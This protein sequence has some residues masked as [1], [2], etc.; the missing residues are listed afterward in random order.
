MSDI[1]VVTVQ[2]DIALRE[3]V[4]PWAVCICTIRKSK[5]VRA[6]GNSVCPPVA[7][8]L[9]RANCAD[10]AVETMEATA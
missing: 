5:Q 2:L 4:D 10:M 9:V 3:Q 1:T 6:C 8:A 7:E